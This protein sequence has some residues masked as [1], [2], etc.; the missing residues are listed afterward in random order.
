[1]IKR[2]ILFT[3][4]YSMP[5][6]LWG[7]DSSN[8]E[9]PMVIN[10][11]EAE[12]NGQEISLIGNV[13]I[14]HG[15]GKISAHRL[16]LAP[17]SDKKMK[18]GLLTMQEDVVIDLEG[19]GQLSCQKANIDYQNLCGTFL[20]D[21]Q[22]PD[23]IYRDTR[24]TKE[25]T[26]K[27]NVLILKS[28]QIQITL[29]RKPGVEGQSKRTE[30]N[31]IKADDQVKA[32]Y[33]DDYM[34]FSDYATYTPFQDNRSAGILFLGVQDPATTSCL[35]VNQNQDHIQ[36]EHISVDTLKRQLTCHK[37]K[38][39]IIINKEEANQAKQEINF[40]SNQLVWEDKNQM[41]ALQNDVKANLGNIGE[42]STN[43]EV[44]IYQ[45]I[46]DGKKGLRT[47]ISPEETQLKYVDV[48]TKIEHKLF[49]YGPLTI[50]HDQ[51]QATLKSPSNDQGEIT[52]GK[53]VYLEDLLGSLYADQA[54]I[55]YELVNSSLV[56][57]KIIL[58]GHVKIFNCFDGHIQES[59][60]VLQ[61]ALADTVEYDPQRKEMLLTSN[62]EKRVL[63]YDKVNNVQM[64]APALKIKRD[65]KSQKGS[66]QGIGDVRFTFIEHELDQLKQHFKLTDK[67]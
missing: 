37:S 30:V 44:R 35:I 14:D 50:D 54:L 18:F 13:N 66:I 41:L 25:S 16:K 4:L 32:Y 6:M 1:M 40:S 43:N 52:E 59:G 7:D 11:G 39:T 65:E 29:T 15:L 3:M 48:D 31:Q 20:G 23:V 53:Q 57:S 58:S 17:S 36:A 42:L 60:S 67:K 2:W 64:S 19:G 9:E 8:L 56:P 34:I 38:G 46:V 12:Y 24:Q 47:I 62:K 26:T 55:K 10:S 61:Y 28:P 22:R 33:N 51:L 49:C 27:K 5:L 45:G 21:S 63:L